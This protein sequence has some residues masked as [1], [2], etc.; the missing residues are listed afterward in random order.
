MDLII[1]LLELLM[2]LYFCSLYFGSYIYFFIEIQKFK[3]NLYNNNNQKLLQI[4][5]Y[6][7]IKNYLRSIIVSKKIEYYVYIYIFLKVTWSLNIVYI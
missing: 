1:V 7:L 6:K 4:K 3:N 2:Q 5:F